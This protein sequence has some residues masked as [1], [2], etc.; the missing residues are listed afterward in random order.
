MQKARKEHLDKLKSLKDYDKWVRV[1]YFP[2]NAKS[3]NDAIVGYIHKS[4]L[5]VE[6]YETE[7]E[8]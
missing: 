8:I 6:D 2:P 7:C 4:Q 3:A 1:I 5:D